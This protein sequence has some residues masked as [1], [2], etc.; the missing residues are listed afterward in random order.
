M[1]AIRILSAVYDDFDATVDW[2]ESCANPDIAARFVEVFLSAVNRIAANPEIY[3]CVFL[4][5]R[6][7][8]L[9]P[10]PYKLFFRI[11]R[12]EIIVVLLIHAARDPKLVRNILRTTV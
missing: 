10:F 3:R 4:E 1:R 11:H 6:R 9:K 2:Y 7:V 8:L 5:F 12:D